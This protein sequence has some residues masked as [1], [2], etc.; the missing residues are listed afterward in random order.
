[1]K[2]KSIQMQFR[3]VIIMLNSVN[4]LTYNLNYLKGHSLK[5][6]NTLKNYYLNR[7]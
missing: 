3:N 2:Q 4:F 5:Q 6:K 1:M 7:T